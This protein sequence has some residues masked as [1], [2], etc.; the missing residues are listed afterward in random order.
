M[1]HILATLV[2][3]GPCDPADIN[4]SLSFA[5]YLY[6]ADSGAD[7]ILAAGL[8]PDR[9]FGDLD[10]ISEQGRIRLHDRLVLTDEQ[11][12]T[13]FDKALRSAGADLS[14]AVGFTGGRLD[15]A[16]AVLNA[17]VLRANHPCLVLGEE[18]VT[19]LCPPQLALDLPAGTLVSLFPMR[20]LRLRSTGLQWP[21][22]DLIFRP[23]GRVGTSN[24]VVGKV[25][26]T[27]SSAGMLVILPRAYLA[28]A[29]A[30]V[31][32]APRWPDQGIDIGLD[33]L[34]NSE[35]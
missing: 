23:D 22:N 1:A 13:D 9:V 8:V 26:L 24:A 18:D 34:N 11:V 19:F 6:G 25:E 27:P 33:L 3:G 10:S 7:R 31:L 12:T 17:L 4:L 35:R 15:H 32:S 28:Q 21:T 2:G 20:A 5:P 29:V 16:L 30:A 14:I